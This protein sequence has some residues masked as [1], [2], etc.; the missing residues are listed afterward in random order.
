MKLHCLALFNIQVIFQCYRALGVQLTFW[1]LGPALLSSLSLGP[2]NIL[3]FSTVCQGKLF[4]VGFSHL[5]YPTKVSPLS[6][7]VG[8]GLHHVVR[9]FGGEILQHFPQTFPIGTSRTCQ[10]KV[11]QDILLG[12]AGHLSPGPPSRRAG[13]GRSHCGLLSC[14]PWCETVSIVFV[15]IGIIDQ[16]RSQDH[17]T[18]IH[19]LA[20]IS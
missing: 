19:L 5:N 10:D 20:Y 11:S 4:S 12:P 18:G 3:T 13:L 15:F 9:I 8:P 7:L 6:S 14:S 16:P 17:C 2:R 1:Q